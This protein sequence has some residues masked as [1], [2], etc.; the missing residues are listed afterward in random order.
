MNYLINHIYGRCWRRED[1]TKQKLSELRMLLHEVTGLTSE[2]K[3]TVALVKGEEDNGSAQF[4]KVVHS[5]KKIMKVNDQILA[6]FQKEMDS[7]KLLIKNRGQRNA[8]FQNAMDSMKNKMK[9]ENKCLIKFRDEMDSMKVAMEKISS[10]SIKQ[11]VHLPASEESRVRMREPRRTCDVPSTSTAEKM[12]FSTSKVQEERMPL[13]DVKALIVK[14]D[15]RSSIRPK[16]DGNPV[17]I[18][19]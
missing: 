17:K 9:M 3:T 7:V 5:M 11:T 15:T 18:Y 13:P 12:K 2:W 19:A 10:T 6:E 14:F 1:G 4:L 16:P 8:Q